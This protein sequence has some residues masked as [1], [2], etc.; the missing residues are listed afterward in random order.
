[1]NRQM[2][3]HVLA[4]PLRFPDKIVLHY[5]PASPSSTRL[6]GNGSYELQAET[7]AAI[8]ERLVMSRSYLSEK[9]N[10]LRKGNNVN[11][12]FHFVGL[13]DNFPATD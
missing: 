13:P 11:L 12:G 1:M 5:H 9:E 7:W 10:Q 4:V 8:S 2:F 3:V 6:I